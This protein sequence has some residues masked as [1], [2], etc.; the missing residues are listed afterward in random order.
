MYIQKF[1][2]TQ[3][4]SFFKN[5]EEEEYISLLRRII[6]YGENKTNRTGI[7]TKSLCF[8]HLSYDLTDTF[9]ILTTRRQYI[10]GIFEELLFYLRGQT[11]N[12]ILV[13]KGVNV[14]LI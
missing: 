12:N 6:N 2:I 10:R 13:D 8:E 11:N 7:D 3:N 4:Y 9:P 1:P 5:N 14:F